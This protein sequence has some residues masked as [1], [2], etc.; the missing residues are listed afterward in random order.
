MV[1]SN[2][3]KMDGEEVVSLYMPML[4]EHLPRADNTYMMTIKKEVEKMGGKKNASCQFLRPNSSDLFVN[5]SNS[6]VQRSVLQIPRHKVDKDVL[7]LLDK[8]IPEHNITL[9]H[10]MHREIC[11]NLVPDT[12]PG[13]NETASTMVPSAKA[14]PSKS[15]FGSSHDIYCLYN[16]TVKVMHL[17]WK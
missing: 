5:S 12:T 13:T 11:C 9:I 7:V 6:Q 3:K 14:G 2:S 15:K 16:I 8:G 4:G 17:I 1:L 10:H